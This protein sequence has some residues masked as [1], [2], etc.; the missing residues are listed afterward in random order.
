MARTYAR[1][2]GIDF[3]LADRTKPCT[4]CGCVHT[5]NSYMCRILVQDCAYVKNYSSSCHVKLLGYRHHPILA[6]ILE[7]PTADDPMVLLLQARMQS[8]GKQLRVSGTDQNRQFY[9]FD[10]DR[11]AR[12]AEVAVQQ[13]LRLLSFDVLSSLCRGLA[14]EIQDARR[15]G[16]ETAEA[17][18]DLK[19][20]KKAQLFVQKAGSVRSIIDSARMLLWDGELADRLD[21]D[22]DLL[23]VRNGVLELKTGILRRGRP[24]DYV[25]TALDLDY[26][27]CATPDI[28]AFVGDLFNGDA[29]A[30]AYFH[31]L[32]GYGITGHTRE[33][34]WAIWTG[35]GSNGKSLLIGLLQTLLA[36]ICVTMPKE[37]I[38]ESGRRQTDGGPTPH[39]LPLIGKRLGVREE[40]EASARLNEELIKQVTGQSR[41]TARGCFDKEYQTFTATHLPILVCNARPPIDTDDQAM[42]RR[43][44]CV[45]FKNVYTTHDARRPDAPFRPSRPHPP[46][47]G[48]HPRRAP[49]HGS[50]PAAAAGVA[51]AWSGR[52]V[53]H[54]PRPPA[55]ADGPRADVVRGR[56]RV[57]PER[58]RQAQAVPLRARAVHHRPRPARQRGRLPPGT[59]RGDGQAVP[60]AGPTAGDGHAR[61]QVQA[62][63]YGGDR[64]DICWALDD[65]LGGDNGDR[66]LQ[67]LKV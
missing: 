16:R 12:T 8:T 53:R 15:N 58:Q 6:R 43:I 10:G 29:E 48:R 54:W 64:K 61:L 67:N 24:E 18:A 56:E 55:R 2:G 11:W 14:A 49:V 59:E 30:I 60:P 28:D 27:D 32:L 44:V 46:H 21:T 35:S 42:L 5:S 50:G 34:V 66:I 57:L 25:S 51:G 45:P 17:S 47:Q 31:R 19:Q 39:L 13:E 26:A 63:A 37:V 22:P 9:C 1:I 65:A 41:I 20:F 23:G 33:Q 62:T 36:P 52:L 4:I 38:F 3:V 7:T 40:K